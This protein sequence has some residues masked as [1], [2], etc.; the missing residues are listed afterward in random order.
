VKESDIAIFLWACGP[1]ICFNKYN[2]ISVTGKADAVFPPPPISENVCEKHP[3][4]GPEAW[5]RP[6]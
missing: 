6:G 1:F 4:A 3:E 5:R 2:D